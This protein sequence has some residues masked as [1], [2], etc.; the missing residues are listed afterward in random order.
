[1]KCVVRK[2]VAV[3][4]LFFT[5]GTTSQIASGQPRSIK[6]EQSMRSIERPNPSWDY[7][8]KRILGHVG[9]TVILWD[10]TTG[11]VL[12]KLTGHEEKISSVRFSPDGVHA[13][14]SSWVQPGG[15][16]YKSKDTRTLFWTW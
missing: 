6:L 10:A 8:G 15:I 9:H 12:Q 13:F 5:V 7:D 14:S 4:A 16:M 1:M 2:S 3:V 11:K